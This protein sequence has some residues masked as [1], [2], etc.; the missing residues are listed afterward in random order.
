MYVAEIG[1][2]YWCAVILTG[3]LAACAGPKVNRV[4]SVPQVQ[5]VLKDQLVQ[6]VI[7]DLQAKPDPQV[8]NMLVTSY[9]L[10][11]IMTYH[12]PI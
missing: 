1:C 6:S 7:P 3:T 2:Y 10:G 5:P 12:K 4:Q 8:Q 9:V 11:A